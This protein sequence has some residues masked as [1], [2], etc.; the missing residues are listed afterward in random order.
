MPSSAAVG[1]PIDI[2][3]REKVHRFWALCIA[4]DIIEDGRTWT[5]SKEG[6]AREVERANISGMGL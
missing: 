3:D 5:G 4:I 2:G 1:G 6:L